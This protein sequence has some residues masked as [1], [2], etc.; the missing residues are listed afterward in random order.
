MT[1]WLES[2]P[3]Q[4]NVKVKGPYGLITQEGRGRFTVDGGRRELM[5]NKVGLI[6][7]GTGITPIQQII[8]AVCHDQWDTTQVSLLYGCNTIPDIL[9][10]EELDQFH[11]DYGSDLGASKNCRQCQGTGTPSKSTDKML[12]QQVCRDDTSKEEGL[13]CLCR[14]AKFR[15]QQTL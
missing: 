4:S 3:L 6:G 7:G 2:L 11:Q 14:S 8:Q 1:Q 15:L 5:A 10:K 9:L 13:S 12:V